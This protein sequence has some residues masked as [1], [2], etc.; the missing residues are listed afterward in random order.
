LEL[1][2]EKV[3]KLLESM[4]E[5]KYMESVKGVE[6]MTVAGFIAEVGDVN[7]YDHPNQIQKLVGLNLKENSTGKNQGQNRITKR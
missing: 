3:E 2:E 7:N 4:P 5:A 6:F 1:L